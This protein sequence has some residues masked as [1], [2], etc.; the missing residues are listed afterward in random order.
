MN[1]RY[2]TQR[3]PRIVDLLPEYPA[4][5][6]QTCNQPALRFAKPREASRS[7]ASASGKPATRPSGVTRPA[8]VESL[9]RASFLFT[10]FDPTYREGGFV[11]EVLECYKRVTGDVEKAVLAMYLSGISVKNMAW[12]PGRRSG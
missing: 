6:E 1:D 11:T 8:A 2:R 12:S 7:L 5:Q 4:L 10:P 3:R 9:R